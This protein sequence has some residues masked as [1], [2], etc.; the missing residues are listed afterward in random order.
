MYTVKHKNVFL[1]YW[2]LVSAITAV[3]RQIFYKNLEK[4]W[5]HTVRKMLRCMGS[6]LQ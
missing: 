3:V 6:H 5:L 1:P 2:L 4:S